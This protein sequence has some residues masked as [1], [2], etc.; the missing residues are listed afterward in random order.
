MT[1]D[2]SIKSVVFATRGVFEIAALL[3]CVGGVT[4]TGCA[5]ASDAPSEEAS[6]LGGE[7]Q[8]LRPGPKSPAN[9][10]RWAGQMGTGNHTLDP[11]A[12]GVGDL[13]V[14]L[15]SRDNLQK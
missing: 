7:G 2:R 14:A 4:L 11:A 9:V 5:P 13:A 8:A 12:C 3:C 1:D 15:V 6:E 10:F